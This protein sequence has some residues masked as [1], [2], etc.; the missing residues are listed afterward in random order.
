MKCEDFENLLSDALGGELADADRASFEAHLAA[1]PTCQTEHASLTA[2]VGGMRSLSSSPALTVRR[3]GDGLLLT[4]STASRPGALYG[5]M[6]RSRGLL[7]NAAVILLAFT[8]G[9]AVNGIKSTAPGSTAP[10]ITISSP[11]NG[12]T[13]NLQ[14]ALAAQ[15]S[16]NPA[17]SD[18]ANGLIA[19][20]HG[21]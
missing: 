2:A 12:P 13:G 14:T 7:R 18:L 4:P 20:Y 6:L 19:M 5:W 8:A 11:G 1:C 3:V 10:P 9:Y 16:R 21:R 17:R 15:F